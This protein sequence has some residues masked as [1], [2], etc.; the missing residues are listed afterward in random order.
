[1]KTLFQKG[2]VDEIISRIENLSPDTQNLW[3]KMN[4]EQMLAHCFVG[5]KTATGETYLKSS[6]FIRM[7]GRFFKSL[8]TNDKQF[9][10]GNPTHKGFVIGSTGGFKKEKENLVN[11]IGKFSAAGE[12]ICTKN[13]HAFFGKLT[14][15][16]WGSLMYKHTDHH[17]RQFGV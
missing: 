9:T 1:M 2:T 15:T 12:S 11:L 14:P 10:H 8:T 16:Q 3:G 4:V 17:L 5:I 13:P 6:I 7:I